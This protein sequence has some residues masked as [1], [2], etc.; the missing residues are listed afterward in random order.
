MARERWFQRY[1]WHNFALKLLSVAVATGLWLAVAREPVAEVAL[2]VPI[3]F[4]NSP[5]NLEISSENIPQVQVR[6]RGPVRT[7]RE[8]APSEVHAIIDLEGAK[9]PERTYDLNPS[10]ITVPKDVDVVQVVPSQFRVEFDVRMTRQVEVHPRVLGAFA[11]GFR[12]ENVSVEPK[13]MTIVGPAKH[14]A[15]VDSVSTDP[16]DASGLVGHDIFRTHAYVNDPMVRF[17]GPNEVRVIVDTEK[18][19]PPAPSPAR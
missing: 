5:E 18:P 7:V 15:A 2:N 16:V 17:V 14:V 19:R 11:A 13:M 9:P 12:I 4:H 6:I 10:R 1:I 8:L 3:E